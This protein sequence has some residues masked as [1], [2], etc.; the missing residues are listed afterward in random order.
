MPDSYCVIPSVWRHLCPQIYDLA[1][2]YSLSRSYAEIEIPKELRLQGAGKENTLI[3]GLFR[4]QG[5]FVATP[6]VTQQPSRGHLELSA[7]GWLYFPTLPHVAPPV[8][9]PAP[10]ALP[11]TPPDVDI[12]K[13]RLVI[14]EEQ[15]LE[16]QIVITFVP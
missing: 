16:A 13:Y 8:V 5:A 2:T 7:L 3:L 10:P 12:I 15:S 4:L 6:L 9:T 11:Y 14:N 1:I